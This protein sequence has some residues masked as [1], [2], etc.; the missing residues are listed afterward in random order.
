[1]RCAVC[2]F[3]KRHECPVKKTENMTRIQ[4]L[5]NWPPQS[6][7]PE[8]MKSYITLFLKAKEELDDRCHTNEIRRKDD[9]WKFVILP[10]LKIKRFGLVM[11]WN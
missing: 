4:S 1:M 11:E 8:T 3:N 6:I 7:V 5:D 2:N 10:E 9:K